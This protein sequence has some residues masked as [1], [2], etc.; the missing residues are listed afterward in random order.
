MTDRSF[1]FAAGDFERDF[2]FDPLAG[3]ERDRESDPSRPASS[4]FF[5]DAERP[6]DD[7]FGEGDREVI[8]TS[9]RGFFLIGSSSTSFFSSDSASDSAASDIF[10][11]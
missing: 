4:S 6:A 7:F 2:D 3:L 11:F 1:F 5:E 10:N 9:L 8:S